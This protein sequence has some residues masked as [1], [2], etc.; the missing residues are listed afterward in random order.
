MHL[1]QPDDPQ[2][3]KERNKKTR[4]HKTFLSDSDMATPICS[5]YDAKAGESNHV[6]TSGPGGSKVIPYFSCK[7]FVDKTL[8]ERCSLLRRRVFCVQCLLP[9]ADSSK[10]KHKD[11]KCQH[12]FACKN[13]SHHRFP[14]RKH[15]LLCEEH[16]DSIENKELLELYKNRCISRKYSLSPFSRN[17]KLS[18][19]AETK[20]ESSNYGEPE[21][22]TYQSFCSSQQGPDP[23]MQNAVKDPDTINEKAIYMF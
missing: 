19:H 12:D 3:H 10:S 16:K 4:Y 22:N 5:I 14:S 9:G 23:D 20:H 15:V 17:I 13:Q 18:F 8:A 6:A 21:P 1:R 7:S 2:H 11:G